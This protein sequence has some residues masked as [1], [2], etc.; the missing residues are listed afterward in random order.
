MSSTSDQQPWSL[1]IKPK[2]GLLSINFAEIWRYRDLIMLFVRRDL[3]SAYK[4][5]ILGPLWFVLQPAFSTITYTIVFSRIAGISTSGIPPILFYLSGLVIWNY[6]SSSL[7]KTSTSLLANAG[8]FGKVYFPRLAVPLSGVIS[9]LVT[10]GVQLG[11]FIIAY[12]YFM[13]TMPGVIKPKPELLILVPFILLLIAMLGM[14]L[15]L[16]VSALTTRFRDLQ[17]FLGF[18][19]QLLMY[20]TPIVYPLEIVP[21]EFLG[22]ALVNPMTP[23]IE[24]F[25]YVTLGAGFFSI[26]LLAFS[27]LFTTVILFMGVLAFNQVERTFMDTV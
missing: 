23:L 17:F 22:Y 25:R 16:I 6:F 7:Q 11:L 13:I 3:V 12:V 14:G 1:E 8:I 21:A 26:K 24:L 19:I 10:F 9:N 15:G 27:A 18:G 2:V 4:Q 5:T 20:A